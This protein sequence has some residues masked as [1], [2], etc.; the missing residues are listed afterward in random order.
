MYY[1]CFVPEYRNSYLG[2]G[3]QRSACGAGIWSLGLV[4]VD[5]GRE[6]T[7]P[8]NLQANLYFSVSLGL[9]MEV[10]RQHLICKLKY[11]G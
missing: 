10:L 5:D 3:H 1:T 4:K 6:Q 2:F 11:K 9:I 8:P 7:A